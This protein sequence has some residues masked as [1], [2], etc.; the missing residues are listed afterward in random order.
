MLEGWGDFVLEL[1]AV[2]RAAAAAGAGWIAALDHE[3]GNDAVEDCVVEVAAAGERSE[4]FA[5]LWGVVGVQLHGERALLVAECEYVYGIGGGGGRTIVVSSV[6]F[7]VIVG[8]GR[9]V[10]RDEE[11]AVVGGTRLMMFSWRGGDVIGAVGAALQVARPAL[12]SVASAA[13][14]YSSYTRDK[15]R[16][17]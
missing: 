16:Q 12:D 6:T 8:G 4:V 15:R 10:M 5:C 14:A 2:N 17:I 7:V 1:F 13:S 9:V 11:E 3:V